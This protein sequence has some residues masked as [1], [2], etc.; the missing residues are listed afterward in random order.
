ME[1]ILGLLFLM[2]VLSGCVTPQQQ[3]LEE[4]Q[5]MEMERED[6]EG[7]VEESFN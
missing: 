3:R 4:Y 7:V 6:E 2:A 1:K 5:L